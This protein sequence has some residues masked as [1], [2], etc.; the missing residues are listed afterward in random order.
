MTPFRSRAR[1]ALV[2]SLIVASVACGQEPADPETPLVVEAR[3]VASTGFI[4]FGAQWDATAYAR[5][6]V[7]EQDYQVIE[8]RIRFMRLPVVR[9]MML[10]QWVLGADGVFDFDSEAMALLYRQL[11][12]CQ[13]E[14]IVVV[15]TD[16]GCEQPWNTAPGIRDTA[17]P[18]YAAAIGTY[19][20]HLIRRLG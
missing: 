18:R 10:T 20:D 19:L 3:E 5:N 17:D 7:T 4:G 11:D 6:G 14:G 1:A 8:K 9:K 2:A 13:R 16:W 12:V 15:L